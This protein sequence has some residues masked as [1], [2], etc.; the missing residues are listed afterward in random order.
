ME[1]SIGNKIK[2]LSRKDKVYNKLKELTEALEISEKE[3]LSMNGFDAEFIGKQIGVS[4]SN[5]S[6]ELNELV[7]EGKAIKVRGKPVLFLDRQIF[8]NKANVK[9]NISV[10]QNH[11]FL[12]DVISRSKKPATGI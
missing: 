6:R 4:R 5:V 12:K 9:L 3:Q 7:R 2:K 8:E 11:K 1:A 10:I